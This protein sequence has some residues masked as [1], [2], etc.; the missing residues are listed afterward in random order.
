MTKR[1]RRP[2]DVGSG[3]QRQKKGSFMR[4]FENRPTLREK[5]VDVLSSLKQNPKFFRKEM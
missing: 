5:T 3:Y 2:T 4:G 1:G